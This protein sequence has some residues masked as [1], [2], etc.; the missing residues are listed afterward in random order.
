MEST[1][2]R[3]EALKLGGL[4]VAA[5]FAT[6]AGLAF[7]PDGEEL[8]IRVGRARVATQAIYIYSQ[9][10]FNSERAG[11]LRRDQI[12]SIYKEVLADQG[13]PHNPRWYR[14]TR[15]YVHS[16]HLQ[17][18]D[19]AHHYPHILEE[20]PEN[21][22]LGQ[23]TVAY[24]DSL[25]HMGKSTWLPLYRLYYQSI[26]WITGIGEGPDNR[27]WYR[28]TDD[29]LHVH[30]YVPAVHMRP[31]Q[32]AELSPLS[33]HIP[34]R[35]KR[36]EI[37]LEPQTLTAFESEQVVL[38]TN[39]STGIPTKGESPNG[40]PTDTPRGRFYVQTKMPSRHMGDGEL[41]SDIEAYELLG[42][43]WV[44][45]FHVDGLALHG[46]YWHNNF[47]RRMSHG[48]VNLRNKDAL[49]LY[50]WTTPIAGHQDW[51]SRGL[52]TQIDIL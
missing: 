35:E 29:L 46:T 41:T 12:I 48:C 4:G 37:I 49:W 25:R 11:L 15:G 47:G 19:H 14:T 2:S 9:P 51:F 43:P 50:R 40:I 38:Q 52:G 34:E 24:S 39:V 32:A 13:P 45:L 6:P 5:I 20:I 26:H 28:I 36:I 33:P 31:L 23:V 27:P 8:L 30:F 3:R 42:V 1:L 17:R 18:V 22:C 10:D 16:G 21:G 7:P 44:C